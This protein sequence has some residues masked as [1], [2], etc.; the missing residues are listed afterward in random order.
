MSTRRFSFV[1]VVFFVLWIL[2]FLL[3]P[4]R[5]VARS[6]WTAR[7]L[8]ASTSNSDSESDTSRDAAFVRAMNSAG[9]AYGQSSKRWISLEALGR[10]FPNDAGICAAQIV[11]STSELHHGA[12][13]QLGPSSNSDLNWSVK[14]NKIQPPTTV[15]LKS[16]FAAT[17]RG[18]KLEPNNT[19]W[20]WVQI[21]GLLAANRDDEV[22][23][24]LRAARNK[25]GYDDHVNDGAL[26]RLRVA[27]QQII[28]SP[29]GQIGIASATLFPH[30]AAMR[31]AA[32]QISDDASGLRLSGE[33]AKQ[34]QALEGLR[35]FAQLA[36][37]MR[38]ESKSFIGSLVGMAM[39]S[40]ALYGGSYSPLRPRP[41]KRPRMGAA[42][43][44]YASHPTS[45]V[46]FART[47]GRT[48]IATQLSQQWVEMGTWR[49]K[50]SK[51]VVGST[52]IGLDMFDVC[53]AQSGDWFGSLLIAP[54]PTLFALVVGC[55]LLLRFV[56]AWRREREAQPSLLSWGW[57]PLLGVAALLTLSS[58]ALWGV[59]TAW[60]MVGSTMFDLLLS[61]FY[62]D[63]NGAILV[64]FAWQYHFP[65]LLGFLCALWFALMWD[66]RRQGMP[67]LGTRLRRLF[68]VPDD[69]MARFDLS[70]ILTLSATIAALFVLTF[71][72][73][74]FLIVPT[75]N[76]DFKT[77]HD[78]A[79]L[80]L[81]GL[82]I[83][84]SLPQLLRLRTHQGR[85][86]AL[87]LARRFAWGQLLFLTLLWG[88]LWMIAMPAQH[89]FDTQF[90]RQ[91]Q[92]GEFQLIRKQAGL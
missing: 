5:E 91:L 62:N 36:R 26:A 29:V 41:V 60:H 66:S 63:S 39:E 88:I 85:A 59:W 20:D 35:D 22:W 69:G 27:Q 90:A 51:A 53:L 23:P 40:I 77:M 80:V 57:G 74:G 61:P 28:I 17:A 38:R 33:P 49:G 2:W 83:I 25:T 55:S 44:A 65:A 3:P 79:G 73:L 7:L 48:D 6:Q 24:V 56:P 11:A 31:E 16:W 42:L 76:A 64:P 9:T 84:L 37:V 14:L 67:T 1:P 81:V 52:W 50:T 71:G 13:R 46:A 12:R 19:F 30:Y 54:M 82:A 78:Y 32:R 10:R 89:R 75:V 70:P 21:M 86:F 18:A 87:I 34:K 45:L 8:T 68:H 15:L 4:T 58:S 72:V 47:L 43:S 92:I